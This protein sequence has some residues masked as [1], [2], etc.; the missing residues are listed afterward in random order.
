MAE[1]FL[2]E[3]S[4]A[5]RRVL[6]QQ[7]RDAGY[8]ATAFEDGVQSGDENMLAHADLLITDL[9]MPRVDGMAVIENVMRLCPD[10]P[11]IVITGNE[12]DMSGVLDRSRKMS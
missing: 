3:D 1:I 9:S 7:I 6:V 11:I 10:L 8:N 2:M 5:L 12:P 4:P